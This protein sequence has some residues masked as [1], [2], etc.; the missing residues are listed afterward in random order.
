MFEL[1]ITIARQGRIR[2]CLRSLLS[3]RQA[4]V[5]TLEHGRIKGFVQMLVFYQLWTFHLD[6]LEKHMTERVPDTGKFL[7]K[8]PDFGEDLLTARLFP[9]V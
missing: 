4:N 2:I 8:M 1:E 6:E 9:R 5:I 3:L 7:R